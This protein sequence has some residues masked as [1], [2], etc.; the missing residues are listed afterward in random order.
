MHDMIKMACTKLL[1]S[2]KKQ[3]MLNMAFCRQAN[4]MNCATAYISKLECKQQIQRQGRLA[5]SWH[6]VSQL[7][8]ARHPFFYNLLCSLLFSSFLLLKKKTWKKVFFLFLKKTKD[9]DL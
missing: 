9:Q 4:A 8:F 1:G 5:T 2:M 7:C 6:I 3:S